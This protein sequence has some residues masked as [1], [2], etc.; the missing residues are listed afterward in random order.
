M[1][2]VAGVMKKCTLCVDRSGTEH[3]PEEDR[4]PACVAAMPH[5]GLRHFGTWA[6]RTRPSLSSWRSAGAWT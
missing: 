5:E 4:I 1:D 3:L 6:T 2:A